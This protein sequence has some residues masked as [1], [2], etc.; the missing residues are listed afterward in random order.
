MPADWEDS[1][2][3]AELFKNTDVDGTF[4]LYDVTAQRLVGYDRARAH[5]RFV[6]ASTFKIPN[7]L[8]ELS[9]NAVSSVDEALP[10]A[11]RPQPFT[12]WERNMSLREAIALSNV[13]IY[14]ELAWRI[15]LTHMRETLS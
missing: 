6:P 12:D 3:V 4:V 8:I 10:Y 9:V 2:R 15:G 1:P 7:T 11:G 13:A 14:R 5:T